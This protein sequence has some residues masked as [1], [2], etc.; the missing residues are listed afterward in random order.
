MENIRKSIGV[1]ATIG[2]FV[3]LASFLGYARIWEY[4]QPKQEIR[5]AIVTDIKPYYYRNEL[6]WST[7]GN[8]IFIESEKRPIDFPSDNWDKTVEK[9]DSVDLVV[10]R[11]FPLFGDELDGIHIDDHK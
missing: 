9:G 8:R 5:N 11:S 2:T 3:G 6:H 4:R 1:Y 7:S 10:R